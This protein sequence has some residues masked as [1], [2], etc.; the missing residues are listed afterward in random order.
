MPLCQE[1]IMISQVQ[2]KEHVCLAGTGAGTVTGQGNHDEGW[3]HSPH[4]I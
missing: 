2:V 4:P 1:M 3:M